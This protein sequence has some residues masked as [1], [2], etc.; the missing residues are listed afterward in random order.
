MKARSAGLKMEIFI[1]ENER[2]QLLRQNLTGI[3]HFDDRMLPLRG[4]IKRDIP[5]ILKYKKGLESIEVEGKPEGIY[6]GNK[7]NC[8]ITLGDYQYDCLVERGS[9]GDRFLSGDGK[10]KIFVKD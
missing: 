8:T 10:V 6:F 5:L 3:L 4:G 7:N 1:S 9:C 2:E